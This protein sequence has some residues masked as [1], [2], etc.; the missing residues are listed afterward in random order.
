MFVGRRGGPVAAARFSAHRIL[1]FSILAVASAAAAGCA[2]TQ[3]SIGVVE[4]RHKAKE[5]RD[6]GAMRCAP[7]ELALADTNVEFASR[8]LDEGDYLRAREHLQ[9]A[10]DNARDA[11][12]LSPRDKCVPPPKPVDSDGDGIVDGADK[13]PREPEDKDGFEDADGCPDPDN[14][15]DGIADANDKCPNE[16]EDK[17]GFEDEDG[18]PDPDNDKDG[19]ADADDKCPNDAEDKDGFEDED[20]CPD[21]DNDN[22][23]VADAD[24]KCPNDPGP[25]DNQ[26][27]PKKYQHIV[28]TDTKIELKQKIFF[29]TDKAVIMARS[30]SLLSEI[31]NVLQ[32]RPA[33]HVRIEGHTDARG[34]KKYNMTLSQARADAVRLYLAGMGIDGGRMDAQ[35]FGPEQPIETNKT[36]AGREKNRRV[37][38]VITQQ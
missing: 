27:C 6:N 11:L 36:A 25:P 20:G 16:A 23:G 30:F 10:E 26:G 14:D 13:C 9:I 17:D 29:E 4:V 1:G 28:V 19:I 12:R 7:R 37:E 21:F 24:D 35:G 18:C 38:F 15:K 22:D 3:L 8:E 2:G 5:A 34:T 31:A 33:M 32:T